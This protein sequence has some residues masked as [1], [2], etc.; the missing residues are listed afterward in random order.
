VRVLDRSER[1]A[2]LEELEGA[3]GL[4]ELPQDLVLVEGSEGK[5]RAVTREAYE[6]AQRIGRVE[7]LGLYVLKR[8]KFGLYLSV[9]GSQLFGEKLRRNVVELNVEQLERWASGEPLDLS[10]LGLRPDGGFVVV[11]H[12]P[13]YAGSGKVSKDGKVHPQIP[14]ER[15]VPVE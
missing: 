1:K 13:V 12:G 5:V 8:T 3:F 11:R 14:K 9:E 4:E 2:L 7:A 15:R 10:E 6:V